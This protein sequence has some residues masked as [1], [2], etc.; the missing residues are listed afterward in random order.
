MET[1]QNELLRAAIDAKG[2]E[3]K[4][5]WHRQHQLE[6]M[7]SGDP[8]V[9]GKTSPVLFPIVGTLKENTYYYQGGAY[10]LS[11]H[12][13]ARD[14]QF[15][16]TEKTESAVRFSLKSDDSTRKV[17]PFAFTFSITY[18]LQQNQLVVTYTVTNEDNEPLYFS[19][20]GHPAFALPL[21]AG[22][23]YNDYELEFEKAETA[24]RWPISSEGLIERTPLPFLQNAQ[25]ILLTKELFKRDAI[26]LKHLQSG[27]V[28]LKSDKTPH[29][30]SF[31]FAGFPYLGLW[32]APGADF[33]CIEPWCGIADPVD[34]A[35]NLVTKEGSLRLSGGEEF[36]A[37]WA[38]APF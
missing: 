29:G 19:V 36:A 13:F 31:R 16:V 15:T 33:L 12:G 9:W 2:A 32:A 14:K 26:V 28:R 5:L 38:V 3:L 6:Y 7:W 8:A 22:T 34:A 10:Q 37:S 18:T 1:I 11:R 17:Y 4:S 24:G 35:Q 30:L 20:G 27:L 25:T 21:V 23:M